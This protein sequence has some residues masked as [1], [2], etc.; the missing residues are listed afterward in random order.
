MDPPHVLTQLTNQLVDGSCSSTCEDIV[1][2]LSSGFGFRTLL[3][4]AF[5]LCGSLPPWN[6]DF[7]NRSMTRRFVPWCGAGGSCRWRKDK[8]YINISFSHSSVTTAVPLNQ[9]VSA[10]LNRTP[11]TLLYLSDVNE[12]VQLHE[13]PLN[14]II[15]LPQLLLGDADSC[16]HWRRRQTQTDWQ[17]GQKGLF[18]SYSTMRI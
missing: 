11:F 9:H 18:H 4:S 13:E 5:R 1:T 2:V 6:R 15:N 12:F 3:S 17:A 8:A 10:A 7:L 14:G 16:W